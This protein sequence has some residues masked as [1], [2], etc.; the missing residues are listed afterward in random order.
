M[1]WLHVPS[2]SLASVP[3]PEASNSDSMPPNPEPELYV[4][5]SGKPTPR[6]VSWRGWK[7]RPWIT[8]L[9]GTT[10]PPSTLQ[11]GVDSWISS[12][13]E[14]RA[15]QTASPARDSEPTMTDGSP[16]ISCASS[17]KAGLRVYSGKTCWGTPTGNSDISYR[18]WKDWA[19]QL[20][21]EYSAR[22]KSA[23]AIGGSGCSSWPT[24]LSEDSEQAGTWAEAKVVQ[25]G[26][27]PKEKGETG[28]DLQAQVKQWQTPATDSSRSRGGDRK[29][30]MG[31]DQQAR[32]WPTPMAAD[33]GHKVTPASH[34]SGL[35]GAS[36]RFSRPDP[37]TPGGQTSSKECRTLNPLFVEWLMGWPRG[38]TDLDS[39]ATG[40]SLFRRR[41]RTELFR[42]CS[43]KP[44]Q[45]SLFD[46]E[47]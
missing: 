15:S 5:L 8:R 42:L 20:R 46:E 44:A 10:L 47:R 24:A 34:Q 30:E 32:N 9:F 25:G 3:V 23:E 7:T 41:M 39:P 37:Q 11:R 2:T 14:T 6:P 12:L 13:R 43:Q 27:N 38:W 18:H 40:W 1:T 21:L 17:M 26:P 19:A 45:G 29:D 4:T 16:S 33:D 28:P 22:R 31:L 35:I 36:Y